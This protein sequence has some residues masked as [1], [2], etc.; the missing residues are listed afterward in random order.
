MLVKLPDNVDILIDGGNNWYGDD[1]VTYLNSQNVDDIEYLIAT[2]PDADHID[3]LVEVLKA[4]EVK[5]VYAPD[6]SHTTKTYN[7]FVLEVRKE[8][9][10]I[11]TAKAGITL[12]N[13]A[14]A[15]VI[16]Y[17]SFSNVFFVGPVKEYGKDLNSWSA[18]MKMN[19]G[20][21]TFLFA[22]DAERISEMDMIDNNIPLKADVLKVGHH[23]SSSSTSQEFLKE[24]NP[25]YAIISVGKNNNYGH[26]S[27]EVL[28]R[29]EKHK[30]DLFRTDLQGVIISISEGN[31]INFNVEPINTVNL[32]EDIQESEQQKYSI[33]I[34]NLD[35]FN[36]K[37]TICNKTDEDVDLT[38][39]VLV[40]EVGS[41]K[42]NF[43]DGYILKAGEC[44]NILSGRNAIEEPPTNFK[45]T[46]AYIWNNDGDTAALYDNE[47]ALISRVEF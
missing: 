31:K 1:I 20:N 26:P 2:H 44:V 11:K 43:P 24:V 8:G 7:D 17:P 29:L 14:L 22:G 30:V 45:W 3:G 10:Y 36:E 34:T 27:Q 9:T 12:I 16:G 4:F 15:A 47:G 33:L 23:G 37:V 6:V 35:V 40:S 41:Q 19:F 18:V 5:N 39:W 13:P 46:G 32:I 28:E 38:G 42:F 21:S 25:K